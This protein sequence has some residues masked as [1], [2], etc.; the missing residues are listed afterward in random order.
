M[1]LL[2]EAKVIRQERVGPDFYRMS[3]EAPGVASVARPGQFLHVRCGDTLDPLLR[4]PLSIHSVGRENGE[5]FLL[6]RVVGKGTSLLSQKSEGDAVSLLGP[7]GNSFSMPGKGHRTAF[8][9]GGIGIAPLF[10]LMQELSGLKLNVSIF[11]GAST[12]E[13]LLC[14]EDIKEY[15]HKL[16]L[17]T[18]DGSAGFH[19]NVLDL[20]DLYARMPLEVCKSKNQE[21]FIKPGEKPFDLVYGCGPTGMLKGLC[22]VIKENNISGEISLEERMGCGVGACLSCVCKTAG[23]NGGFLY[24]RTCIEGPVLPARE[25]VWD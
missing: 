24:R 22:K 23:G 18:D 15:G 20:F 12:V 21:T 13:N 2:T 5:V 10:F 1:S 19:G 17:A 25:V 16:F 7:L 14:V 11:M 8:V 9:A 3:L 4:R 6:Y